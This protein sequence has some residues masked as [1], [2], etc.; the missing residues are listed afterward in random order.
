MDSVYRGGQE[1]GG[2]VGV[3]GRWEAEGGLCYPLEQEQVVV[4][5][6]KHRNSHSVHVKSRLSL[7]AV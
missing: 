7:A 6:M 4:S 1:G 2:G 5:S 3:G